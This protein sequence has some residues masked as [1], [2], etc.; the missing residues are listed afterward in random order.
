MP[1]KPQIVERNFLMNQNPPCDNCGGVVGEVGP[2]DGWQLPNGSTV[3]EAC[4]KLWMR[5]FHDDIEKESREY[6]ERR[7]SYAEDILSD[8][9]TGHWHCILNKM[10]NPVGNKMGDRVLEYWRKFSGDEKTS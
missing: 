10:D 5:G 3:C 8:L 6:V 4:V 2:K 1:R 9:A 7:L